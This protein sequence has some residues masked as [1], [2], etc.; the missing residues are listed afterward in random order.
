MNNAKHSVIWTIFDS[1]D[2]IDV[3]S[4]PEER[5]AIAFTRARNAMTRRD[6]RS[7]APRYVVEWDL[8]V[9]G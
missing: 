3:A 6:E 1:F 7:D 4:F 8:A 2:R 5:H 9:T